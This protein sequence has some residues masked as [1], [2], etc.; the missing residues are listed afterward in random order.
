MKLKPTAIVKIHSHK[1]LQLD[2]RVLLDNCSDESFIESSLVT[3]LGLKRKRLA[4]PQNV[5]ALQG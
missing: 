1:G 5:N 4:T 2:C 3:R